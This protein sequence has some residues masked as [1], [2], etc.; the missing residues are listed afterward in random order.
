MPRRTSIFDGIDV[1]ALRLRL[2]S[3]QTDYLDLLQGRKVESA[4]YA[5]GD[6]NRAVT[7]TKANLGDLTQAIIA[8]QTAIDAAP[9][10]C[11]QGRRAPVVPYF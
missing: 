2:A 3:M 7:Y 1:T 8:V 6:G 4:S 5:Q 9:G 10:L 11:R